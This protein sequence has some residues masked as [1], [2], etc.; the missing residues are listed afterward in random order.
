MLI[1]VLPLTVLAQNKTKEVIYKYKKFER[2]DMDD[3]SIEGDASNPGDISIDPRFR[4]RFKNQL[5]TRPNFN[6]EMINA[7]DAIR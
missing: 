4:K 6:K 7:V 2:F 5:P 1:I 3:I